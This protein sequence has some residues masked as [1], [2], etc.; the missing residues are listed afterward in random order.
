MQ[1]LDYSV[2]DPALNLAI[3]EALLNCA[4]HGQTEEV[5]RLW[6]S[7]ILFAVLGVSQ[8]L[9]DEIHQDACREDG[10]PILRRCSAGGCVLQGPGCLNFALIIDTERRPDLRSLKSSYCWILHQLASA[11]SKDEIAP[12][13]AGTCDLAINRYKISGNAQK[14]RKRFFLHHGTLLHGLDIGAIGRY[15][16]EPKQ[17]P[18]YRANRTHDAFVTQLTC[19]GKTLRESVCAA[20]GVAETT[21]MILPE[22]EEEARTLVKEKYSRADWINRR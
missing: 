16:R 19:D 15:L 13:L 6:E 3:D 2:G 20:F 1:A 17:R 18:D 4:E 7:P 5:L 9:A 8:C 10:I 11:L 22:I 14:R 12:V 21:Q